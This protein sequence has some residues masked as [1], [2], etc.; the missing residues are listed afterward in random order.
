M[1]FEVRLLTRSEVDSNAI[2]DILISFHGH[3]SIFS[4]VIKNEMAEQGRNR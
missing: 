3:G 4:F 2:L 1:W